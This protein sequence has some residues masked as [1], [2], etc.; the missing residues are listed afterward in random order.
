MSDRH[1]QV[2]GVTLFKKTAR[3][4][5][6]EK[7]GTPF[8]N[9]SL[10]EPVGCDKIQSAAFLGGGT[11]RN[12][13]RMKIKMN[14]EILSRPT[15]YSLSGQF[16]IQTRRGDPWSNTRI[17]FLARMLQSSQKQSKENSYAHTDHI[18]HPTDTSSISH[19]HVARINPRHT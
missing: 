9:L 10:P 11:D 6:I 7:P 5:D 8:I 16:C 13:Q 3:S 18:R 19:P 17:R 12:H 1:A 15:L 2:K 14:F 4:V